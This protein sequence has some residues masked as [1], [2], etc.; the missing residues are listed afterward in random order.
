MSDDLNLPENVHEK[1]SPGMTVLVEVIAWLIVLVGLAIGVAG[2]IDY[3][4]GLV[5]LGTVMLMGGVVL[6]K[7]MRGARRLLKA[8][9]RNEAPHP[10]G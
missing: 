1:W 9:E 3:A 6:V 2:A 10:E 7:A 8:R 4:W 5:A